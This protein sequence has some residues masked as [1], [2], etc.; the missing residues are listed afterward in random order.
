MSSFEILGTIKPL[1]YKARIAPLFTSLL[2]VLILVNG[3]QKD[4]LEFHQYHLPSL[5]SQSWQYPI[6]WKKMSYKFKQKCSKYFNLY[7]HNLRHLSLERDKDSQAGRCHWC[8]FSDVRTKIRVKHPTIFHQGTSRLLSVILRSLWQKIRGCFS[9]P[10]LQPCTVS[11]HQTATLQL[12]LLREAFLPSR[13]L[14]PPGSTDAHYH[15]LIKALRRK[16]SYRIL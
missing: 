9:L 12:C 3:Q 1:W 6:T 11:R 15:F 8:L 7:G 2:T 13:L 10:F 4:L 14:H 16:S 5:F